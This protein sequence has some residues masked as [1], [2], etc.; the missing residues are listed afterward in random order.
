MRVQGGLTEPSA[1]SALA[2]QTGLPSRSLSGAGP[3]SAA[4]NACVVVEGIRSPAGGGGGAPAD[5]EYGGGGTAAA[6]PSLC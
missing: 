2:T 3:A 4:G 1:K 6:S 5:G